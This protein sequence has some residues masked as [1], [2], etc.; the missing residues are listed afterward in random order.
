LVVEKIILCH[1]IISL[2]KPQ[3]PSMTLWKESGKENKL[4]K[5]N[6]SDGLLE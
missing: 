4:T 1:R 3:D 6:G 5:N 2:P